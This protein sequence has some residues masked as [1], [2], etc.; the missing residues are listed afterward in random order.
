[1]Y[2]C[3]MNDIG[4]LVDEVAA[5]VRQRLAAADGSLREQPCTH[6]TTPECER[7][8]GMCVVRRADAARNV[9]AAGADR[10]GAGGATGQPPADL[11]AYIDHTLLKAD[12]TR[13]DIR[14]LCE[15]AKRHHFASV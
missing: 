5:R 2:M 4:R 11:A 6:P 13:E 1:M 9:L 10:I 15:D 8:Q 12:A 7:C 14:R 3:S